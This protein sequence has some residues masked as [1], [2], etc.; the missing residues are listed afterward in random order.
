MSSNLN[1]LLNYYIQ[2]DYLNINNNITYDELKLL[3]ES[4]IKY[5]IKIN[6]INIPE[7]FKYIDYIT[8][9]NTSIKI[10]LYKN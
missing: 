5:D 2:N 9:L 1:N 3:I 7:Q 4:I 10:K 6:I 8:T